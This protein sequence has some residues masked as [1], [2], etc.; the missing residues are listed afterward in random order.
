M[1]ALKDNCRAALSGN[2]AAKISNER[3]QVA[4]SN[5]WAAKRQSSGA[6]ARCDTLRDLMVLSARLGGLGII[7]P[8]HKSTT[9]YNSQSI[10]APLG[11]DVQFENSFM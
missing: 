7:N 9:H 5:K 3:Q 1:V 11:W 2:G 10:T 8:S 4:K 6:D